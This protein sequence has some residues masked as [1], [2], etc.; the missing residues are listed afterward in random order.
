VIAARVAGCT[1]IVGIDVRPARLEL[2]GELG[3]TDVVNA[4]ELD[5]VEAIKKATGRGT[6]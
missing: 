5:P 6:W 1:T 4:A 2:A 3:A